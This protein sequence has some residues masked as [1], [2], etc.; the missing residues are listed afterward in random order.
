LFVVRQAKRSGMRSPGQGGADAGRASAVREKPNL[1][2]LRRASPPGQTGRWERRPMSGPRST[3]RATGPTR[4][5]GRIGVET[6]LFLDG[7]ACT[8]AFSSM[9]MNA[10]A[11]ESGK[12][13]AD[14]FS[15]P[16]AAQSVRSPDADRP[17]PAFSESPVVAGRDSSTTAQDG[18]AG[19]LP[20][21]DQPGA[22][23]AIRKPPRRRVL[24][25]R[26]MGSGSSL[27]DIER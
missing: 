21:G 8:G 13:A 24:G 15:H 4:P 25:L 12:G 6:N 19:R 23:Q 22:G 17:G 20:F 3:S 18:S 14:R 5:S 16:I 1:Q 27:A 26:P 7:Q 10:T 11:M 2:Q 9:G